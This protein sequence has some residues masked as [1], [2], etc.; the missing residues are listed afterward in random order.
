M[1]WGWPEPEQ[2]QSGVGNCSVAGWTSEE[3]V[4]RVNAEYLKIVARGITLVAASGD[5]GAPGDMN[6]GC[7]TDSDNVLSN[8]FPASSPWVT[9]VGAT[10]LNETSS[11]PFNYKKPPI[12][13]DFPCATNGTEVVCTFPTALITTGGGFST[14]SPLPSWQAKQV[15]AYLNSSVPLPPRKYFNATNRAYPDISALGHNYVIQWGGMAIQV[16]GTS[17]SSPVIAGMIALLN[18]ARLNAGK[19]SLGFINP[20][21]YTAA[22]TK[23]IFN[24]ITTGN[25][26]CTENCCSTIGFESATGWDPVTGL[27]T[28]NFP[29]LLKYVSQLP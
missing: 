12:C 16:D 27:G 23:G 25:N 18:S 1:S 15:N 13:K 20:M 19:S 24:D 5:Q 10:M 26:K 21:L 9:A 11:A 4:I 6:P 2:C 22:N 14:Y 7:N 29:A 8:L 28:P 3:Y 17:C